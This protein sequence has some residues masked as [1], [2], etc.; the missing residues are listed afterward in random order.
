MPGILCGTKRSTGDEFQ[1][2][3]LSTFKSSVCIETDRSN[4]VGMASPDLSFP[5]RQTGMF[6]NAI[7]VHALDK[8]AQTETKT[9]ADIAIAMATAGYFTSASNVP[10]PFKVDGCN[11]EQA[12]K[13]DCYPPSFSG[14]LLQFRK[15]TY[16]AM[17]S[18]NNNFTNRS[19][20]ARL[21]VV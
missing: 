13:L 20:K 14:F 4:I 15:G 21:V 6:H 19:Q 18:R 2:T 1:N 8:K 10:A 7:V 17:C 9:G 3:N 5:L 16:Y 12:A 11:T